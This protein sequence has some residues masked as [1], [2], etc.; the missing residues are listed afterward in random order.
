MTLQ[1][2]DKPTDGVSPTIKILVVGLT[3][4]T[5]LAFTVF[6]YKLVGKVTSP[7]KERPWALELRVVGDKLKKAGLHRQAAR[8]YAKFLENDNIDRK[9]RALVSQTLGALY[10]ELGD[11]PSA[12]VWLYQAEVAGPDPADEKTLA[13][14]IATCLKEVNSGRP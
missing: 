13:S 9:T 7:S 3:I 2:K 12:L 10:T 4:V 5:V 11:C 6:F 8:Q 14:Q 1:Q